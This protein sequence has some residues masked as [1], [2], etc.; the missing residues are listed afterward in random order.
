MRSLFILS[1]YQPTYMGV[2]RPG[3]N[4]P[5]TSINPL[6]TNPFSTPSLNH[7]QSPV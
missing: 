1:H 3:N 7:H 5:T 4:H 2:G 6:S